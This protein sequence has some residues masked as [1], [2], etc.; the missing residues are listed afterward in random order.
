MKLFA[1][2]NL[3]GLIANATVADSARQFEPLLALRVLTFGTAVKDLPA[4][5][6]DTSNIIINNR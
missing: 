6:Q 4:Q 2:A 5:G 1:N 3:L